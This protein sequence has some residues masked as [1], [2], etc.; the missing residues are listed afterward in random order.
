MKN[1]LLCLLLAFPSLG[2]YAQQTLG[3]YVE[4]DGVPAFVF[5]LDE[6]GEH[7]LAM[8]IPAFNDKELKNL[9]KMVKKGWITEEQ[10]TRFASCTMGKINKQG[11]GVKVSQPIFERLIERLTDEGMNNQRQICDYCAENG[12]S[13]QEVFP[14]Q[15]WAQCLGEGWYIPGDKELTHFAYFYYGGLG[16]SHSLGLKFQY[17]ADE[18]TDNKLI[19]NSLYR[20]VLLGL[21]S[22]S[23]HFA[24]EGFRKL[25]CETTGASVKHWLEL[26]DSYTG[27]APLV[28]AVHAF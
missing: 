16:R 12:I 15:Y 27:Q 20:M 1:L 5:Y 4:F 7:G 21:F 17:H 13:L 24:D 28:C 3:D 11:T 18:L 14:M 26:F 6:T 23:S 9:G 25:R 19:R 2:V 22:S 8:S 10:A